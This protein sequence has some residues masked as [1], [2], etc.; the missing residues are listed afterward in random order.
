ML[1]FFRSGGVKTRFA[2]HSSALSRCCSPYFLDDKNIKK[3][4]ALLPVLVARQLL[5]LTSLLASPGQ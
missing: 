5:V 2:A 1:D 4:P 3:T